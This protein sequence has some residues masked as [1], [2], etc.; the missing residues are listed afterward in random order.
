[1]R[2]DDLAQHAHLTEGRSNQT[3]LAH[4]QVAE[5]AVHKLR[6]RARGSGSEVVSLDECHLEPVA[7]RQL[8]DARADYP[9]TDDEHVEPL[10][11]EALKADRAP[12]VHRS[13]TLTA[14]GR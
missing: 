9:T 11:R 14:R 4:P 12:V 5:A 7:R 1:M 10:A 2:S 3:E 13:P 8:R 6:G